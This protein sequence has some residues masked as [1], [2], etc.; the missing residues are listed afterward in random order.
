MRLKIETTG[1]GAD[2][3]TRL[4]GDYQAM[5]WLQQAAGNAM[6]GQRG[7]EAVVEGGL[8]ELVPATTELRRGELVE[9]T[10]PQGKNPTAHLKVDAT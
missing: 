8:L 10:D 3:R 9:A 7:N 4:I 2:R 5:F 6:N 1:K